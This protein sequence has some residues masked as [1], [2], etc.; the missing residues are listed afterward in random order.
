[1]QE[2]YE[3]AGNALRRLRGSSTPNELVEAEL[4][5]I[6]ATDKQEKEMAHGV[7]WFDLFRGTNLRRTALSVATVCCQGATGSIFF[8]RLLS[9]DSEGR[10]GLNFPTRL[11]MVP[12]SL[13]L[14]E[15]A[16]HSKTLS[17]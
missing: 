3:Q 5:E 2:R 17:L 14:L 12:I 15:L 7:S 1:M 13:K 16:N 9:L 11:S 8:V 10:N 6:I 4:Q